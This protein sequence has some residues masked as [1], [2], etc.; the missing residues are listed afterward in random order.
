MIL[1]VDMQE[2]QRKADE[3]NRKLGLGPQNVTED[4]KQAAREQ[5][6]ATADA[7]RGWLDS[8]DRS[9]QEQSDAAGAELGERLATG[10]PSEAVKQLQDELAELRK[11]AAAARE[12]AQSG[13]AQLPGL[14]PDVASIGGATSSA[15]SAGGALALGFGGGGGGSQER[16]VKAAE[17]TTKK[18]DVLHQDVVSLK[19]KLAGLVQ[20][21]T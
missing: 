17:A 1:G 20:R 19:D 10:G 3:L 18:L 11:Q 6:S 5:S 21:A 9:F 16:M 15:F 7:A 4:A 8:L 2:E 14:G 13:S 12:A